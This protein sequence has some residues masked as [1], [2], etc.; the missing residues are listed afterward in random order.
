MNTE[1][2]AAVEYEQPKLNNCPSSRH[3]GLGVDDVA[4]FVAPKVR[5]DICPEALE[6]KIRERIINARNMN[7]LEQIAA[8]RM[9]GYKNSSALSKIETGFAKIPKDFILRAALAYGVS[10]DYLMGL[11]DEPERDPKT[12]E[13]MAI[14]R[15]VE[16]T[17]KQQNHDL[18]TILLKNASDMTPLEGHLNDAIT[19]AQRAIDSYETVCL[20][21]KRFENDV[22]AGSTLARA[23]DA[24][25]RTLLAAKKFMERRA[26]LVQAR[27]AAMSEGNTYPLFNVQAHR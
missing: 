12:A 11:S 27:T 4:W 2:D 13:H 17:I 19:K 22:L 18:V 8:A 24:L 3:G 9:L 23:M 14:M 6:K 1:I 16:A 15:S 20:R 26:D 21:N 5:E 10:C 7:R 25:Q